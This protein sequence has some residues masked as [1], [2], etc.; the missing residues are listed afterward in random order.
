MSIKNIGINHNR[1]FAEGAL[2]IEFND[3]TA[4]ERAV[5]IL[6][7]HSYRIHTKN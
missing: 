2:R 5:E 7:D 6:K 3:K 1:E 4:H